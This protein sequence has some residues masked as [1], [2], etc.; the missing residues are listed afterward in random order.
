MQSQSSDWLSH[1]GILT[2]IPCSPNYGLCTRLLKIKN[3][4]KIG[5]FFQKGSGRILDILWAFFIKQLFTRVC[6]IY[7]MI[8]ANSALL[9][10]L[11]IYPLI[12]KAH[13]QN[14]ANQYVP[15][16]QIM[17]FARSDCLLN[18]RISSAN[19]L[20]TSSSSE[21]ANQRL[22]QKHIETINLST[23]VSL[24]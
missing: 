9:A 5:C 22:L 24:T 15:E 21:Q 14:I 13:S 8:I 18:L 10:S 7:V 2:L 4:L 23:V 19:H 17:F 1:H 3:K 12:S 16:Q 11:A 20:F 6:W